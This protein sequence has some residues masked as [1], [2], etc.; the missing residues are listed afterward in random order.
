MESHPPQPQSRTAPGRLEAHEGDSEDE[1]Q[2]LRKVRKKS[3][4]YLHIIIIVLTQS[5]YLLFPP[6][7]QF[8]PLILN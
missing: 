1:H 8:N 7:Q 6:E 4:T 3:F 5:P 2:N